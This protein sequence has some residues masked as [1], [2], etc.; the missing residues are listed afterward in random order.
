LSD[1]ERVIARRR[2]DNSRRARGRAA[3][4]GRN[5]DRPDAELSLPCAWISLPD[6]PGVDDDESETEMGAAVVHF[7]VIGKDGKALTSFYTELFGWKVDA[8]NPMNYGMVT[9]EGNINAFVL[10]CCS[11][12]KGFW[13]SYSE[14][15]GNFLSALRL[16]G[17]IEQ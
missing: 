11:L 9:R 17:C 6:F 8:N 14:H 4:A 3:A 16:R 12:Q 13:R 10:F 15:T 7:E 1:A 5:R 2:S